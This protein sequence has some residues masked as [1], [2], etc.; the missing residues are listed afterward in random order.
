MKVVGM[1]R[2]NR[3]KSLAKYEFPQLKV[4]DGEYN[5]FWPLKCAVVLNPLSGKDCNDNVEAHESTC[6]TWPA[7]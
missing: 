5:H 1:R 3:R 2:L 4:F 6:D 7:G